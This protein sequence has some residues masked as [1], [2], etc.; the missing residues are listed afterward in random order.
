MQR[1]LM[2]VLL[3]T[4][5]LPLLGALWEGTMRLTLEIFNFSPTFSFVETSTPSTPPPRQHVL[6]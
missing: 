1:T 2:Y 6:T 4:L 3:F 5:D